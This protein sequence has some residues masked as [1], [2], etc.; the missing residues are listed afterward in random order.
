ML[1]AFQRATLDNGLELI[2]VHR[3]DS[4]LVT[5]SLLLDAGYASDQFSRPGTAKLA[6]SMLEDGTGSRS[7]LE[8]GEEPLIEY[9]SARFASSGHLVTELLR[10]IAL[11]EGF[12]GTSGPRVLEESEG[13]S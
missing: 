7:S 6:M 2:T 8:I 10:E 3:P 4:P 11:S 13:G 5:M 9:L 1:P 12:R